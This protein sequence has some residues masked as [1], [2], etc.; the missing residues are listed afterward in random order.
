MIKMD[1]SEPVV[2]AQAGPEVRHWGPYQF[3]LIQRLPDGR[4]AVGCHVE[5]DS[6]VA[7]G[8]ASAFCIS[9][10]EGETWTPVETGALPVR[11][12]NGKVFR[13][14]NGDL[15]RQ[16]LLRS[17][18][19]GPFRDRLPPVVGEGGSGYGHTMTYFRDEAFPEDLKGFQFS[20][21]AAGSDAWVEESAV[22]DF[23]GALRKIYLDVLVFPWFT[24]IQQSPEG[25]LWGIL[26]DRRWSDG[27]VTPYVESIFT[28]SSDGGR[29]WDYR[30]SIPYAPDFEA[31]PHAGERTGFTE[32]NL[33]HLPD[34]SLLA[35]L[36]TTDGLGPG[37]LYVARSKDGARTWSSPEVFDEIGVCPSLVSLPSGVTLAAYGRPGLFLRA[38]KDPTGRK[39][40]ERIPIIEPRKLQTDT[41]SYSDLLVLSERELLIAYSDFNYPDENGQP[42]KT[43]L[44]RRVRVG[45]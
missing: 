13:L 42:C 3:P 27:A 37:P 43:I 29:T 10:D 38:C 2:V 25:G 11:N 5:A 44:V 35:L 21:K 23:P 45:G 31:D 40:E 8:K 22:V 26:Y 41:C 28:Y 39:W 20:R 24:L 9:S 15:L 6:A 12:T 32:P 17:V 1:F 33:V 18:D 30:S 7:Y 19:P 34:G 14:P 16:E 36:R 4:L